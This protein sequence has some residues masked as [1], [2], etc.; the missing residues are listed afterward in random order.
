[1]LRLPRRGFC[2][3]KW[4]AWHDKPRYWTPRIRSAAATSS[5]QTKTI[6]NVQTFPVFGSSLPRRLVMIREIT[7]SLCH[8]SATNE[9]F[10]LVYISRCESIVCYSFCKSILAIDSIHRCKT[11]TARGKTTSPIAPQLVS[12]LIMMGIVKRFKGTK[13]VWLSSVEKHDNL[14][15]LCWAAKRGNEITHYCSPRIIFSF[16]RIHFD[17]SVKIYRDRLLWID[18]FKSRL[19]Y[20]GLCKWNPAFFVCV[21]VAPLDGRGGQLTTLYEKDSSVTSLWNGRRVFCINNAV[22]LN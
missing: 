10:V 18:V 20:W 16:Q 4:S 21:T 17:V 9:A 15:S 5:V 12:P 1:M 6:N 7:T 11:R 22:D 13:T 2:Q 14:S 8:D 19:K 3:P